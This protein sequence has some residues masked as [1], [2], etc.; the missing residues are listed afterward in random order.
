MR[1]ASR[2][3]STPVE[4]VPSSEAGYRRGYTQGYFNAL[5][6]VEAALGAKVPEEVA[7][8]FYDVLFQWRR[9]G[10]VENWEVWEQP[11]VF[12]PSV[13]KKARRRRVA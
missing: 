7:K 3:L 9:K 2:K 6:A 11:P 1:I 5:E 10:A 12:L 8:F 13:K 4:G